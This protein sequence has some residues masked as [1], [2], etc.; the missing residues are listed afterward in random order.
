MKLASRA[1]GGSNPFQRRRIEE[2]VSS[3]RMNSLVHFVT[4]ASVRDP[5]CWAGFS[6]DVIGSIRVFGDLL[7]R[8]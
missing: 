4:Q 1:W 6:R 8:L 2:G 7:F 3:V 5:D